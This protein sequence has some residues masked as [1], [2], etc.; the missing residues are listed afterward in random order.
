VILDRASDIT[1]NDTSGLGIV[2]ETVVKTQHDCYTS[3]GRDRY[4]RFLYISLGAVRIHYV[5]R[6]LNI[7]GN[8]KTNK[9]AKE[10]A[11]L[12]IPADIVCILALLKELQE[13][14]PD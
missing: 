1:P 11:V 8:K 10:S 3:S 14:T 2:P 12:L 5:P 13:Q 9:T 7:L 4:T 6:Y